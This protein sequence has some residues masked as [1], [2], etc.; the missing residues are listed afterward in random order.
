LPEIVGV[1]YIA[2]VDEGA[3]YDLSN[4][5]ENGL[6]PPIHP[7]TG[8]TLCCAIYRTIGRKW[9]GLGADISFDEVRRVVSERE[10]IPFS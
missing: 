1:G 7:V 10:S 3:G 2:L 8:R 4:T 6:I 9:C 5:L